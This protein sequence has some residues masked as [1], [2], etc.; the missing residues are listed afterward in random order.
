MINKTIA[1]TGHSGIIGSNFLKKFKQNKYIKCNFDI[2]DRKKVFEW[3]KNID[4]DIFLHLAAI[5][6]ITHVNKNKKLSY[7]VNFKGTKNIV[8]AIIK[9][10]K[11]KIWFFYSSTSHVYGFKKNLK[12][13]NEKCKVRPHNYYGKTKVLSEKYIQKK[14]KKNHSFCIGRIFSFTDHRQKSTFFIPRMFREVLKKKKKIIILKNPYS[15]RDFI[16]VKDIIMAIN[17]LYY[18]N[19]KGIFNI[20]TGKSVSL[21]SV[22]HKIIKISKLNKKI[23]MIETNKV[24]NLIADTSKLNKHLKWHAKSNMLMILRSYFKKILK[25]F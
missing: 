10:K 20:A 19:S 4:F 6:P 14:I 13:I 7:E 24:Q 25:K 18:K 9:C 3:I 23:K 1:I 17:L 11:K 21:K 22:L 2:T 15:H 16:D 12:F 8:D 5:V